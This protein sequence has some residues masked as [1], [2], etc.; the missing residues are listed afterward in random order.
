MKTLCRQRCFVFV[1]GKTS[2]RT[3]ETT[4]G[5]AMKSRNWDYLT[6]CKRHDKVK[7]LL[8]RADQL[9]AANPDKKKKPISPKKWAK[10]RR[11]ELSKKTVGRMTAKANA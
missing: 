11:V 2:N 6:D 9:L 1:G 3:K 10:I 8:K 7:D 4:E 5:R